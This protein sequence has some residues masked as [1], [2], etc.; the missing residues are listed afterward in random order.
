MGV[1]RGHL[2]LTHLLPRQPKNQGKAI[3]CH[4][5]YWAPFCPQF[6][7]EYHLWLRIPQSCRLS[8]PFSKNSHSICLSFVKLLHSLKII[9]CPPFL[10][11]CP[12]SIYY[13]LTETV[14]STIRASKAHGQ[15]QML[16]PSAICASLKVWF[17]VLLF[18]L[19]PN[20]WLH[21]LITLALLVQAK[22]CVG[23]AL[24]FIFKEQ[25]LKSCI[26]ALLF[27]RTVSRGYVLC[28]CYRVQFLSVKENA[29]QS[30]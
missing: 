2:T 15:Y 6:A 25:P 17:I 20:I 27:P 22:A 19:S 14:P 24:F 3:Y 10:S 30:C 28:L 18:L 5:I 16:Y 1:L 12:L 21:I 8:Y 13:S 11:Q 7:G 29:V 9:L 4:D 26:S 23:T